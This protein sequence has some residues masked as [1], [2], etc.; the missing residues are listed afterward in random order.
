MSITFEILKLGKQW[1]GVKTSKALGLIKWRKQKKW[2][3]KK[4]EK[5]D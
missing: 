3:E 4:E 1:P 5:R 2:L